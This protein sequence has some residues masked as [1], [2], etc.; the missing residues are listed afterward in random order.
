M[1]RIASRITASAISC[2]PGGASITMAADRDAALDAA[3]QFRHDRDQRDARAGAGQAAHAADHQ[4]GQRDEGQVE[5]EGVG[6]HGAE[7][8]G[9]QDA[10]HRHDHRAQHEGDQPL[11]LR[12]RCR[13]RPPPPRSRAS[14]AAPGHA[15][16]AVDARRRSAPTPRPPA[17]THSSVKR[18]SPTSAWRPPVTA[19][20]FSATTWTMTS[21]AKVA[22]GRAMP[23]SRT[24][25]AADQQRHDGRHQHGDDQRR[26][27]RQLQRLEEGRQVERRPASS[28][29]GW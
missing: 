8:M 23:R 3:E 2:R 14:S 21:S 26:Q 13:S 20:Q 1:I 9:E 27:A 5:E 15:G 4:H 6:G 25:G 11:A 24:S 29:A 22:I 16:S 12:R 19:C 17:P 18:G 28:P 7:E 10:A